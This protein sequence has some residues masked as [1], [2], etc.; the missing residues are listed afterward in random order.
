MTSVGSH[1]LLL[2]MY[3]KHIFALYHYQGSIEGRHALQLQTS[4]NFRN[5]GQLLKPLCSY[6]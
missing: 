2:K 6:L 3:E 5:Q 1:F 4:K